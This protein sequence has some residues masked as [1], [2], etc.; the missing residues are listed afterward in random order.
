[1]SSLNPLAGSAAAAGAADPVALEIAA[2]K[3]DA[4]ALRLL[5]ASGDIVA[6]KVLPFNG[7]TDLIAI[8]GKRVAASLPPTVRPGD[9]LVLEVAGF[10]GDRIIVR[11]LGVEVNA[12]QRGGGQQS[13]AG[14]ASAEDLNFETFTPGPLTEDALAQLAADLEAT[15]PRP[16]AP[17]PAQTAAAQTSDAASNAPAPQTSETEPRSEQPQPGRQTQPQT[18][19]P[20]TMRAGYP[21]V[22]IAVPPRAIETEGSIEARL[23]AARTPAK[24]PPTRSAPGAQVGRFAPPAP[25]S[26]GPAPRAPANAAPQAP[27]APANAAPQA[28]RASANAAPQAL[29]APLPPA[30]A[31]M[32]RTPAWIE[33]PRPAVSADLPAEAGTASAAPRAA[34]QAAASAQNAQGAPAN[35]PRTVQTYQEP[36]ILLR[37]LHLPVTPTNVAAAKLA[38]ETPQRLPVALA[39]LERSLPLG[40]ADPRVNSMRTIAAFVTNLDPRSENFAAQ[41]SAYISHVVE[42]PEP[43]LAQL[44]Q[45]FARASQEAPEEG[46]APPGAATRAPVPAQP[47]DGPQNATQT[48]TQ[49]DVASVARTDPVAAARIAERSAA[50]DADLKTQLQSF[51]AQPP[52]N[53]SPAA[54]G[55]AQAALAALTAAQISNVAG[56][57]DPRA[58]TISI[59]LPFMGNGDPA[60]IKISRE[61]PQNKERLDAD[62]FHIAFVLDTKNVGTVAIDLQTVGRAVDLAV[63]SETPRY[64]AAFKTMLEQLGG[65]LEHLHY[66]VVSLA[67]D[68]VSRPGATVTTA[69]PPPPVDD[70]PA[71]GVD[72]RA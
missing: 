62:N 23:I 15:A 48:A 16:Q 18:S 2:L 6:A 9:T 1:V 30:P 60:R 13:N 46:A 31:A 67:S 68:V 58:V 5:L 20:G 36:V 44:L 19:G 40:N 26:T 8:L 50:I 35:A 38:L 21:R 59:P 54:M 45:A 63:K 34:P 61:K 10:E 22:T 11:N 25:P 12:Q 3:A 39:A 55:T 43:K 47:Q 42:G 17:A 37:S 53:T 41:L 49:P 71:S 56:Q 57:Q 66:N 51:I 33:T 27:R 70:E 7:L 4:E 64:A 14:T 24:P 29:R 32:P 69:A 52:P 72:L 28:P 65:R